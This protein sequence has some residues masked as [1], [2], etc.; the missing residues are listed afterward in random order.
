MLISKATINFCN[1]VSEWF[2][3]DVLRDENLILLPIGFKLPFDPVEFL[4][5]NMVSEVASD[6][7]RQVLS[8]IKALQDDGITDS[9]VVGFDVALASVKKVSNADLI[10]AVDNAN[11]NATALVREV[12]ITDN[13]TAP[14]LRLHEENLLT[15]YP[16]TYAALRER[17]KE[18]L[19]NAKFGREFNT[20]MRLVKQNK[21]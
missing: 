15:K 19:P 21:E 18:Q 8:Q 2:N 14:E 9:I 10:A 4:K 11:P 5:R 20:L 6:F 13:P 17:I 7:V 3:K 12:R 1:F 16:L